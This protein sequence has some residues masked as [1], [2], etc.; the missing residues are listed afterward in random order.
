M[1]IAHLVD[2]F[3]VGGAQRLLITFMEMAKN[4]GGSQ[5]VFLSLRTE[6]V[7]SPIPGLL[8]SFGGRVIKM[9]MDTLLDPTVVVRLARVLRDEKIDVL[10]THLVH[11]NIV[12]PLAGRL[13]DIPVIAT[14]H[15]TRA[16][17]EGRYRLRALAETISLR[18]FS[19]CVIAVGY[20]VAEI[21]RKRLKGQR[22]EVI[23]NSVI[24]SPRLTDNEK[25][26]LREEVARDVARTVIYSVGRFV[27][28]KGYHD[29]IT[30][31]AGVQ[32]QYPK[33]F[34]AIV[35]DGDLRSELESHTRA[36]GIQEHVNFLGIRNDV[37]KLLESGDLYVSASHWEGLSMAMLEAMSAGLPILST[38]VG[39]APQLLADGRGVLIPP[40]NIMA[41]ENAM[42]DLLR[43]PDKLHR[44]GEAG[45]AFVDAN[46]AADA[47]YKKMLDLYRRVSNG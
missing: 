25:R 23:L 17:P 9:E 14:L 38:N 30:A 28:L 44:M 42:C 20:K 36:L 32:R 35:G 2:T 11:A 16:T 4:Q 5:P 12:G 33:A 47:W 6:P 41:M 29:M 45:H 3:H 26:L 46:F 7:D 10:Q 8:E 24:S 19:K 34:L 37:Q 15:S 31:F 40:K 1:K 18:Y 27:P 22:L 13:I 43:D 21:H 39:D